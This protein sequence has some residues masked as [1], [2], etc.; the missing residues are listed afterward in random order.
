MLPKSGC[1]GLQDEYEASGHNFVMYRPIIHFM[2]QWFVEEPKVSH[3]LLDGMPSS[4]KSVAVAALVHWARLS[5]WVAVYLPNAEVLTAGGTF[6][7]NKDAEVWDTPE[8]AKYI[9]HN[10][11][12]AHR[13]ALQGMRSVDG[14]CSVAELAEA[15]LE[16]TGA[17]A[18]VTAVLDAIDALK[19]QKEVPVMLAVD[20]YNALY[21]P[22]EYGQTVGE[23]NRRMLGA[24]ELRLARGL[25]VMEHTAPLKGVS[26]AAMARH[27][28][29]HRNTPIPLHPWVSPTEVYRFS[30]EEWA[31]LLLYYDAVGHFSQDEI[32]LIKSYILTQGN[33][34]EL[35]VMGEA[36]SFIP[37]TAMYKDRR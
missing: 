19:A 11:L 28:R 25:R 1:T 30:P 14:S 13:D 9:L 3:W 21:A 7:Y 27:D 12:A 18:P 10:L 34:K 23:H 16:A 24:E 2:K 36:L 4:G 26:I 17:A 37:S 33:P 6:A 32:E 20:R 35:R 5:G 15:G 31:N 22:S 29:I 8:S